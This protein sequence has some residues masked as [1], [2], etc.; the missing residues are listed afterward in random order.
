MN[1]HRSTRAHR[2]RVAV[3]GAA[4]LGGAILP[5]VG[6]GA[7]SA[8]ASPLS[9][10]VVSGV[11]TCTYTSPGTFVVPAGVTSLTV[12]ADGAS[13]GDA[14][15]G[16]AGEGGET[17]AT[18]AG[19]GLTGAT[20]KVYPGTEGSHHGA[21][22]SDAGN[23]GGS[24]GSSTAPGA[25][26]AGGG[27]S[28]AVWFGT[29]SLSAGNAL[30]V[31]GGGGG[32]IF[33]D[34]GGI[35]GGS[36]TLA[37][38]DGQGN[39]GG[40][41]AGGTTSA[42]GAGG[43]SLCGASGTPGSSLTGGAGRTAT[44]LCD[45]GGGGGGGGF[46]GGG[47][48][49]NGTVLIGGGAGGGGSAYL[50]T[51]PVSGVTVT[52]IS[53]S[54]TWLGNGQVKI[55]FTQVATTTGLVSSVNP[56]NDGQSVTF[57]ATVSPTDGGGSV[58]FGIGGCTAQPLTQL[59]GSTYTATCITSSL[60]PGTNPITAVYS[61]DNSYAG[62]TSNTVNQVV[63]AETTTTLTSS[64]NPSYP[65]ESVTFT[66]T[67]SPTDGGGSVNF[68]ITGCTAQPLILV[69]GSTYQATCT[70]SSLP[71]GSNVITASYSGDTA[72]SPSSDSI[73]QVVRKFPTDL[74]ASIYFNA[75][76]TFTVTA[77]L[78]SLGHPVPGQTVSFSTG[79]HFLGTAT[80]GLNGVARRVLTGSQTLL[81][82]ENGFTIAADF[83]GSGAYYPSF[84]T[85]VIS[86]FP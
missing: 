42:G 58:N 41:G 78:T 61:G 63:K 23:G 19:G 43:T 53:D 32:A 49:G 36:A 70:T 9:C 68:G 4:A 15:L 48:G 38:T 8:L 11:V 45:L 83:A 59:S 79:S 67:V 56:S 85:A 71:V 51:G 72:Y 18:L 62:S 22:G 81:V 50:P 44:F 28:S 77:T 21:G 80:T 33:G 31:A 24:G 6:L 76:Q 52:G 30:A 55:S 34:D 39:S 10:P 75:G 84:A 73:T 27:G 29:G 37:G 60:P 16:N 25:T 86:M 7:T 3:I 82:E 2:A 5:A 54:N 14:F 47:G 1:V 66:A 17:Q 64:Q 13:G 46:Y 74:S 26:G 57:T 12:T 65:G 40:G 20:L 35:G 69:S